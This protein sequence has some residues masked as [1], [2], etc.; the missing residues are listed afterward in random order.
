MTGSSCSVY[1]DP[2]CFSVPRGTRNHDRQ[3]PFSRYFSLISGRNAHSLTGA[4]GTGRRTRTTPA[5]AS[6]SRPPPAVEMFV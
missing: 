2:S 5:I 1:S 3:S 6:S 4:F